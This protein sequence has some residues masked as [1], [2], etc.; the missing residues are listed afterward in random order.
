M[1]LFN[2]GSGG[3]TDRNYD[4]GTVEIDRS[5]NG[6][7]LH[8]NPAANGDLAFE[9]KAWGWKQWK[10]IGDRRLKFGLGKCYQLKRGK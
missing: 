6:S 3:K 10:K 1:R 4:G 9:D 7:Y 5:D 2:G 8:D